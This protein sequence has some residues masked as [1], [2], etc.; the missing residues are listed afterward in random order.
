MNFNRWKHEHHCRY[1]NKSSVFF[2]TVAISLNRTCVKQIFSIQIIVFFCY[3]KIWIG[4]SASHS[5]MFNPNHSQNPLILILGSHPVFYTIGFHSNTCIPHKKRKHEID[6]CLSKVSWMVNNIFMFI[7]IVL[8]N[9]NNYICHHRCIW[10]GRVNQKFQ[11]FRVLRGCGGGLAGVGCW[12]F[13]EP[14]KVWMFGYG[15]PW[16][17]HDFPSGPMISRIK[18]MIFLGQ[19]SINM[20]DVHGCSQFR[21]SRDMFECFW[22]QQERCSIALMEPSLSYLNLFFQALGTEDHRYSMWRTND[23]QIKAAT[24]PKNIVAFKISNEVMPIW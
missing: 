24:V 6:L 3:A 11:A 18:P 19:R 8:F 15:K 14:L 13:Q 9:Y 2:K 4:M 10:K 23:T 7:L 5:T 12:F 20:D 22:T 16:K 17:T 21:T 1:M